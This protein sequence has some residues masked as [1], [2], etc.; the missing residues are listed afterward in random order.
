MGLTAEDVD[1]AVIGGL[2]SR[3]ARGAAGA[4]GLDGTPI[5]DDLAQSVGNT[6][7]CQT[8]LTLANALD[9]A[10]PGQIIMVLN[11]ADGVDVAGAAME[12]GL[13]HIDLSRAVPESV[14]QT[15]KINTGGGST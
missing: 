7:S 10:A 14:V 12:H 5:A 2:H 15:I 11:L 1:L 4:A 8:L 9:S 6:G 3:A 13:L